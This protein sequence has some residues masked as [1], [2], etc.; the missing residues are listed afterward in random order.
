VP[1]TI[2]EAPVELAD[3]V[4]EFFPPEEWDNAVSIAQLESGWS[5]FAEADTR[6]Q[7]HPC[8]AFLSERGGVRVSAEWSI[9]WFQINCCNLPIAW[10]PEHL[11]NTRH[12]VGTAHKMWSDRG[13]EPWLFSAR[14]LGLL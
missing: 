12:N 1:A 10:R 11:F 9:G 7:A 2:D 6:D 8:G 4:R 3:S 13:W 5:A 14:T